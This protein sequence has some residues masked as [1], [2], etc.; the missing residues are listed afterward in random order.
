MFCH[1]GSASTSSR[2]FGHVGEQIGVDQRQVLAA[3]LGVEQV[4]GKIEDR[5]R[6]GESELGEQP[7]PAVLVGV[8]IPGA[9]GCRHHEVGRLPAQSG[10]AAAASAICAPTSSTIACAS[11]SRP[12]ALPIVSCTS[13]Q[14]VPYCTYSSVWATTGCDLGQPVVVG[15]LD[16]GDHRHDDIRIELGDL[17]EVQRIGLEHDDRIVCRRR[18]RGPRPQAAGLLAVPVADRD[19]GDPEGE[20]VVTLRVADRHDALRLRLDHRRS[21]HVVDAHRERP[22]GL[23]PCPPVSVR[24][25]GDRVRSRAGRDRFDGI[26]S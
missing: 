2:Y 21:E 12:S 13:S 23:R 6:D 4:A 26:A 1:S 18:L 8:R 15:L 7:A 22:I 16:L 25:A 10:W 3:A 20:H 11:A 19:R 5:L 24:R 14:G 17:L 9:V